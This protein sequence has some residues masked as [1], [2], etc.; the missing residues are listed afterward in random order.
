[1]N[2]RKSTKHTLVEARIP[3]DWGIND[4]LLDVPCCTSVAQMYK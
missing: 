1:M 2:R 3:D 4:N